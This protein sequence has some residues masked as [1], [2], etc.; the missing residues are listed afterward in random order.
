MIN[1][2]NCKTDY[3]S[4]PEIC[5]ECNFPFIATD[6]EKS[7][8]IG[9]QIMKKSSINSTKDSIK[10]AKI[11]LI[12]IAVLNLL[13][14]V[15][16]FF[17]SDLNNIFLGVSLIISSIFLFFSYKIQEKPFQSILIPLIILLFFYSIDA[18]FVNPKYMLNGLLWKAIFI[19]GLVY[20]L[21]EI[22]ASDKIKKESK[23]LAKTDI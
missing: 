1:C 14:S 11:I 4:Q 21:I 13:S 23:H 17:T 18:I 7:I 5:L 20:A 2:P 22:K 10:S 8:F 19:G 12:S 6:K 3:H 15:F 16:M 9:Q